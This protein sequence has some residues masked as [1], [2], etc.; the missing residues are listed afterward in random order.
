MPVTSNGTALYG[1]M[2]PSI[3]MKVMEF[4]LAHY[5]PLHYCKLGEKIIDLGRD[6][7]V[8]CTN[9]HAGVL[10]GGCEKNFSLAIGSS[11]CIMCPNDNGTV[12]DPVLFS[13]WFAAGDLH[14]CA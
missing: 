13:C 11:H 7:D 14:S 2:Q 10:C 6:P 8:Q 9:N 3:E 4:L 5:C 1:S 12:I